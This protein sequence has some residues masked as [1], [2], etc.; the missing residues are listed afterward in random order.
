MIPTKT[1][2]QIADKL[3]DIDKDEKCSYEDWAKEGEK[4]WVPEDVLR[5]KLPSQLA[6]KLFLWL[7]KMDETAWIPDEEEFEEKIRE[8]LVGLEPEEVEK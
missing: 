8:F 5:Q 6:N 4:R 7:H 1:S 2:C 3:D